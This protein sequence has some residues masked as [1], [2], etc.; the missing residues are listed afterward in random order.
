VERTVKEHVQSLEGQIADLHEQLMVS[1]TRE[2]ANRV[3]TEIRA[4]RMALGHYLEA[5]NI[6]QSLGSG[7]E[8]R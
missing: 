5:L 8:S 6:E 3:E 1:K 4:C 2:Q 7:N